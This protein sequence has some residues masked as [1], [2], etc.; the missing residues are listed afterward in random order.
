VAEGDAVVVHRLLAEQDVSVSVRT[1]ERAVRD[2]RQ[3]RPVAEVA[4][5][6]VVTASGEQLQVDFG[7]KRVEIAGTAVRIHLLV[8]VLSYSRRLF[9]K[10]FLHERQDEWREGVAA[11]FRHF[12]V[13]PDRVGDNARALVSGRDAATSTV[14]FH[15]SYLAF[16]RDWDVQPRCVRALPRTAPKARPSRASNTSNATPWRG[17][18]ILIRGTRGASDGVAAARRSAVPRHDAR[19]AGGALPARGAG[20]PASVAVA[21]AAAVSAEGRSL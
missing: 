18:V 6:R 12:G 4:T 14:R 16:C 15:P 20:R 1:I 2:L 17:C 7:Q 19:S 8:A 11:A 10:A 5:L 13:C 9:V 21:R 3:A